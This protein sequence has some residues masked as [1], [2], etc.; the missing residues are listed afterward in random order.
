[1]IDVQYG[2]ILGKLSFW[3]NFYVEFEED[4]RMC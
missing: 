1:M 4:V 3:Q 2:D